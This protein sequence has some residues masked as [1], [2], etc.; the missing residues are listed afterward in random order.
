METNNQIK[1]AILWLFISVGLCMHSVFALDG[2]F[3]GANLQMPGT[4]GSEPS[5]FTVMHIVFEILPLIFALLAL[6]FS[7]RPFAWV[8]SVYAWLLCVCNAWH[9]IST[10]GE[11]PLSLAQIVLLS[12]VLAAN[13]MQVTVLW[14][15][16]KCPCE[17]V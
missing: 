13:I 11:E 17:K 9:L 1:S 15:S 8:S 4:D 16:L 14:K 2:I 12:F 5:Y 6:F 3:F 10:F 7:S